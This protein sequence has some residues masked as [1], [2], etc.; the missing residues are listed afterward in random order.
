M[1]LNVSLY[2]VE[3]RGERKQVFY[4]NK[5]YINCKP[6]Q[7]CQPG[8]AKFKHFSRFSRMKITKFP[9]VLNIGK[10]WYHQQHFCGPW[11][12]PWNFYDP[13]SPVR[14]LRFP[15]FSQN[16][17]ILI[18]PGTNLRSPIWASSSSNDHLVSESR[19]T[20]NSR[21]RFKFHA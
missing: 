6:V 5:W 3:S 1:I 18:L 16:F 10:C 15:I 19:R 4:Y 13:I 11:C 8:E 2:Y 7:D 21:I 12:Y 9:A 14:I 20:Q 17:C